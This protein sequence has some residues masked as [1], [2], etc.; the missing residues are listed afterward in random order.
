MYNISID[1]TSELRNVDS[2]FIRGMELV[3]IDAGVGY[4]V[5]TLLSRPLQEISDDGQGWTS[6]I[7]CIGT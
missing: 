7:V 2:E 5:S 3:L 1:E 6:L 4:E